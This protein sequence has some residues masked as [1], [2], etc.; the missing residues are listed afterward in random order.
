MSL[1]RSRAKE[2]GIDPA[3]IGMLGFFA[4][5]ILFGD[6]TTN[7]LE[8]ASHRKPIHTAATTASPIWVVVW[9]PP[10][11]GV[12]TFASASTLATASRRAVPLFSK[13]R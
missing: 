6:E 7:L 11:S 5:G 1:T 4:G 10:R 3:D 9:V 12:R 2:S 13:P 8:Q